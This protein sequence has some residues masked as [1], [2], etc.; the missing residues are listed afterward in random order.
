MDGRKPQLYLAAERAQMW[1]E[2]KERIEMERLRK[3]QTAEELLARDE[4]EFQRHRKVEKLEQ[5]RQSQK[6]WE[7]SLIQNR[8]PV[9][10]SSLPRE[11]DEKRYRSDTD[12]LLAPTLAPANPLSYGYPSRRPT[13][14]TPFTNEAEPL[15][16][17]PNPYEVFSA[18]AA[19]P[20]PKENLY[21]SRPKRI[22]PFTKSIGRASPFAPPPDL[23]PPPKPVWGS[24]LAELAASSTSSQ[25]EDVAPLDAYHKSQMYNNAAYAMQQMQWGSASAK[26]DQQYN[27]PNWAKNVVSEQMEHD[28]RKVE[29]EAEAERRANEELARQLEAIGRDEEVEM[30]PE[31]PEGFLEWGNESTFFKTYY[32][33]KS[34]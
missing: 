28:R 21:S 34:S 1:R 8:M 18:A 22:T 25:D 16:P 29:R 27:D 14:I 15:R 6:A 11:E 20:V 33:T 3:A 7:A 9:K 12:G 32:S 19:A 2:Q 5:Q 23:P 24:K 13:G 26:N 30:A 4:R 17:K 10:R 31:Q